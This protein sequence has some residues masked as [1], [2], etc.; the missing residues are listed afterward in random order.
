MGNL[1]DHGLYG[2]SSKAKSGEA[3]IAH[4]TSCCA[5]AA[6]LVQEKAPL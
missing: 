3:R 1:P 4:S 6:A 5:Q 2:D